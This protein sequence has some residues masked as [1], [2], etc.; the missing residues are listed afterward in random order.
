MVV[1]DILYS[2]SY[3]TQ[4]P[5]GIN[6]GGNTKSQTPDSFYVQAHIHL[7][8]Q[9]ASPCPTSQLLIL[10]SLSHQTQ[11]YPSTN[12]FFSFTRQQSLASTLL[13][14]PKIPQTPLHP[15]KFHPP[16]LSL[17]LHLPLSLL[18]DLMPRLRPRLCT[19]IPDCPRQR[20]T[21]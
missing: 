21:C 19:L 18:L 17:F 8:I 16:L 3:C 4:F 13:P 12:S 14:H 15:L 1:I 10:L 2:N 20:R 11:N 7:V 9:N 5:G 6:T